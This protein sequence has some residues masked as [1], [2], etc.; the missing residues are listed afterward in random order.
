MK[1]HLFLIFILSVL[2]V[3]PAYAAWS[4]YVTRS[5]DILQTGTNFPIIK[6]TRM[7]LICD[8]VFVKNGMDRYVMVK[9]DGSPY[10]RRSLVGCQDYSSSNVFDPLVVL[11]SDKITERITIP[12]S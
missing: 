11:N 4:Y 6:S 2:V 1:K 9:D 8:V 3:L 12:S 7:S 5:G 10:T